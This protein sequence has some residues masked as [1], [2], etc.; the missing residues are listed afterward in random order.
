MELTPHEYYCMTRAEFMLKA[1]GYDTK[2][3]KEWERSRFIGYQT[4]AYA[5]YRKGKPVKITKFLP[6]KT[7]NANHLKLSEEERKAKWLRL[8]NNESKNNR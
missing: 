3:V 1:K 4:Y 6:L 5:P 7:D 8:K 2:Q